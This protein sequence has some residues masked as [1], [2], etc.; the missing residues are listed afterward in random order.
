[1]GPR[2]KPGD[3]EGGNRTVRKPCL[4]RWV[5]IATPEPGERVET[6]TPRRL[7]GQAPSPHAATVTVMPS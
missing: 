6:C 5:N 2:G 7:R 4:A 3:D 1:M